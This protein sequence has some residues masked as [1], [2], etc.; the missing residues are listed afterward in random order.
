M[1]AVTLLCGAGLLL[2]TF[3]ELGKVS[4]GF[5]SSHILTLRVSANWGETADM[6][7]LTGQIERTLNEIRNVPGV[8]NA[9]T[10]GQLPGIGGDSR[11][12]LKLTEGRAES[13]GKIIA[14]SRFVSDGYFETMSIP[15]LEGKGCEAS[16]KYFGTVLVNRSFADA[17]L[18]GSPAIGYHLEIVSS[19]FLP[20]PAEI[21]G[22][23]GDAREQG[24]NREPVPTVYWC[25]DAPYPTPYFLIRT[26]VQP[27]ALAETIRRA[28]HRFAPSRSVYSVSTLDQHLSDSFADSRVRTMLLTLFALT[29]VSLVCVGLYGT[30]NYFVAIRKREIGLRLALGA[31][32]EQ[33]A[34]HFLLQGVAVSMAGCVAGLFAAAA[35]ARILA[36]MLY[37][38]SALD[39]RTFVAV[40]LLIFTVA[41]VA[42]LVPALR[43]ARVDPMNVLRDE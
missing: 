40:P 10:A 12:E 37:G 11:T 1:F 34:G 19:E 6:G 35:C 5:D 38:V 41:A 18:A 31:L 15:V 21:R 42:S 8:L 13:E 2:R 32:R 26:A 23:A 36:P 17:F 22:I 3:Q 30:L 24:L 29:A 39:I 27:L 20:T 43:A 14:E 33:V 25:V 7:K 16:N 9:A 28:L 4:P